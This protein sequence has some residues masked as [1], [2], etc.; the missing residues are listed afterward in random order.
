ML[1]YGRQVMYIYRWCN[2]KII[3]TQS[4]KVYGPLADET[5]LVVLGYPD[6][7]YSNIF[8]PVLAPLK[9]KNVE[10]YE[11]PYDPQR[12]NYETVLI[13]PW[14]YWDYNTKMISIRLQRDYLLGR[15]DWIV[16]KYAETLTEVPQNWRDYRQALRDFPSTVNVNLPIEQIV[17]PVSP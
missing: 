13:N 6:E 16:S 8:F 11:D 10:K 1:L 12:N 9:S 3:V 5:A 14:A 17:W 7:A 4:N 15:S 2:M